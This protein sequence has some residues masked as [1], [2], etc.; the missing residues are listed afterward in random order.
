MGSGSDL[1][2]IYLAIYFVM[3]DYVTA[4]VSEGL[5]VVRP[6]YAFDLLKFVFDTCSIYV[7]A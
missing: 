7:E 3:P 5:H 2:E 6:L 4:A 1:P